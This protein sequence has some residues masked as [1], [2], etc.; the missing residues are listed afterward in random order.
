MAIMVVGRW[1]EISQGDQGGRASM[2][3]F[4]SGGRTELPLRDPLTMKPM[5]APAPT[6]APAPAGA[7]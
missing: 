6:D 1:D 4:W 2:K 7:R 5:D 3:D